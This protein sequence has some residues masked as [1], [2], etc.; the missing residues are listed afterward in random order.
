MKNEQQQQQQQQLI[1]SQSTS[2]QQQKA[3]ST[4]KRPLSRAQDDDEDWV[5]ETPKRRPPKTPSEKKSNTH[6]HIDGIIG[7]SGLVTSTPLPSSVAQ[8]LRF[9]DDIDTDV[10]GLDI[11]S[12]M[13][14]AVVHKKASVGTVVVKPKISEAKIIRKK[15]LVLSPTTP[16]TPVTVMKTTVTQPPAL[17]PVAEKTTNNVRKNVV[18]VKKDADKKKQQQTQVIFF[19]LI[20]KPRFFYSHFY[21]SSS[22]RIFVCVYMFVVQVKCKKQLESSKYELP[23]I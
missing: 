3:N 11:E 1:N 7:G 8:S 20:F 12:I 22:V 13:P 5:L 10:S 23:P 14:K 6:S 2:N 17:V 18:V 19:F 16:I 4:K 15:E 21:L 9:D